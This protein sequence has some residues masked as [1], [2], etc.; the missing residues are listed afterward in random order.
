MYKKIIFALTLLLFGACREDQPQQ[1]PP[2]DT[3]YI[4]QRLKL[5]QANNK[6]VLT[7]KTFVWRYKKLIFA[8]IRID[9]LPLLGPMQV[10]TSEDKKVTIHK[11]Y[12]ILVTVE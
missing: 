1:S 10:D 8:D 5:E 12:D 3:N 9:S 7:R 6:F 4:E 2:S 11:Q